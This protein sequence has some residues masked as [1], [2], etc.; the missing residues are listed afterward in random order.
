MK[1]FTRILA[2]LSGTFVITELAEGDMEETSYELATG[3][4]FQNFIEGA[5]NV[6]FT[7]VLSILKAFFSNAKVFFSEIGSGIV[8]SIG[9]TPENIFSASF[10]YVVIGLIIGIWIMKYVISWSVELLSKLIDPA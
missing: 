3:E 2:V 5:R 8:N 7:P 10:V 6:L 4:T 1:W 9:I